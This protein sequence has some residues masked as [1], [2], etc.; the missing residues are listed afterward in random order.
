MGDVLVLCYHGLSERWPAPGAVRP[1]RF[2]AQLG[3]LVD[4]GY[5]GVTFSEAVGGPPEG[6]AVAVT[7]DDGYRSVLEHALPVLERLG[8]PATV[9]VPTA[10]P[11]AD[12]PM[13]W[14][15]IDRWHG[16]EFEDEL[17][18][19][20]WDELGELAGRGWEIGSHTR[21]HARLTDVGEALLREELRA[22]RLECEAAIGRPCRA[23]A[24]P[25]GSADERVVLEAR[26]AGYECG[27]GL[28]RSRCSTPSLCWPRAGIYR[29]DGS[30]RYGLKVSPL[31]RRLR[32]LA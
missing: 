24:Y 30:L 31:V 28:G 12:A 25:Y 22:S 32:E 3:R 11:G 2:A 26:A 19:M 20:R 14:P 10:F 23:I 4:A 21:T 5:T 8:L 7:F 18:P 15:G 29:R 6:R 13:T 27:A 17:V 1:D 16:G 9:F